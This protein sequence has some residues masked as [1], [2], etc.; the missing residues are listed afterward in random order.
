MSN[1]SAL[2]SKKTYW[3]DRFEKTDGYF[4]WYVG[5]KELKQVI[6]MNITSKSKILMVGCGNSKLSESMYLNNFENITNIDISSIV[7]NK[8]NI[9]KISKGMENMT[10]LEM[11]ATKMSFP[12]NE[13]DYVLDKGTLDALSC[14]KD[15]TI[16]ENLLKEMKRVTK[17]NGVFC[18]ITHSGPHA[19]IPLFLNSL[20][21]GDYELKY[22]KIDLSMISNLINSIKSKKNK[23]VSMKDALKDKNILINSL[24]EVFGNKLKKNNVGK[25]SI[26]SREDV[27]EIDKDN[28]EDNKCN[29]QKKIALKMLLENRKKMK[30]EKLNND[31]KNNEANCF[32]YN[33]ENDDSSIK[34]DVN[35]GETNADSES[36]TETGII[37]NVLNDEESNKETTQNNKIAKVHKFLRLIKLV[38]EKKLEKALLKNKDNKAENEEEEKDNTEEKEINSNEDNID[39]NDNDNGKID[40]DNETEGNPHLRRDHCHCFIFTKIK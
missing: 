14:A 11:D 24:M 15:K 19:R 30:M 33:K 16:C 21:H 35:N 37:N 12:D 4:D 25:I 36:K 17:V 28:E 5:W 2:Y 20:S 7:I 9:E 34:Q 1:D 23:D 10:Y 6:T 40:N 31:N 39:Y 27:D 22:E 38:N 26:S 13:F 32:D 8:M 18:V 3:D 29:D